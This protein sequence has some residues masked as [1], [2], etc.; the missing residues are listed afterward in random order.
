MSATGGVHNGVT[1]GFPVFNEAK[2]VGDTIRSAVDQCEIAIVSDNASTDDSA[3]VC[4]PLAR[5]HSNLRFVRHET[6]KGALFNFGYVLDEARTPY[7]MWLGGHDLLPAGYVRTLVTLLERNP[8][9][10]MAYGDVRYIDANGAPLGRYDY[11]F[12]EPLTDRSPWVRTLTL[13]RH[14]S[15]CSLVHGVF[16]TDALRTAFRACGTN[17]H[18][19]VDL[20][21][22]GQVALAGSF[23]HSSETH[24]IRR[25]V[26]VA[27][28]P[29]A[30]LKRIAGAA[31]SERT[32]ATE[33]PSQRLMQR[34]LYALA[35]GASRGGGLA[36]TWLRLR[37]R[38]HLVNRFGGFS[39]TLTGRFADK[40]LRRP[41]VRASMNRLDPGP[42]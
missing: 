33:P 1:I 32:S 25:E 20:V 10:V 4:E 9:A 21:L 35:A 37:A 41:L 7:F 30:Q 24:L 34:R 26:R 22:L 36:G 27:D 12:H 8:E 5:A 6:N 39:D 13:I 3:A 18:L 29:A 31:S 14:L 17:A 42:G 38:Y 16:R 19:G 11:S 23:V 40:I 15:D 2:Y 28:S